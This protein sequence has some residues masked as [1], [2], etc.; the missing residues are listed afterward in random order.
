MRCVKSCC[1]ERATSSN[2]EQAYDAAVFLAGPLRFTV[3]KPL[4]R[5]RLS[6][7]PR[8]LRVGLKTSLKAPLYGAAELEQYVATPTAIELEQRLLE[9]HQYV[10]QLRE[11]LIQR[12]RPEASLASYRVR[13][14][15]AGS[16]EQD[17]WWL[18]GPG[19]R[20]SL[21]ALVYEKIEGDRTDEDPDALL[22]SDRRSQFKYVQHRD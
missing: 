17:P 14:A 10:Q 9:V 22:L 1:A 11:T 18:P 19:A 3:L 20:V 12:G 15:G 13:L 4:G 21:W 16:M 6:H 7:A 5:L 2:L 8:S